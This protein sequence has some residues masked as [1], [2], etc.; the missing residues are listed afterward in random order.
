MKTILVYLLQVIICSGILYSYYHFILR[1]KKFHQ[2]NRFY[3]LAAIAISLL[4][5]FLQIAVYFSN[6]EADSSIIYKS[7]QAISVSEGENITVYA[8]NGP[9]INYVTLQNFLSV[10]Y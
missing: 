5:P 7:L 8:F 6:Q 10:F 1:N 9:W 4:I 2:F 3:L